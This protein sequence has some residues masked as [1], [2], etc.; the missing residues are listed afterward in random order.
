[1]NP[2]LDTVKPQNIKVKEKFL[3]GAREKKLITN[4]PRT[5]LSAITME[6]GGRNKIIS[7]EAE[8]K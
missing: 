5:D 3:K 8:S 6:A 1:M 2:N 4:R 7:S